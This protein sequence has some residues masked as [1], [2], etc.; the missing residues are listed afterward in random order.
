MRHNPLLIV[1]PNTEANT[2]VKELLAL[3]IWIIAANPVCPWGWL[4]FLQISL[5]TSIEFIEQTWF[6]V[7]TEHI[8]RYTKQHVNNGIGSKKMF[9]VGRGL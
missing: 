4:L 7:S 6:G 8:G 1:S 5:R 9:I 3:N 2:Q